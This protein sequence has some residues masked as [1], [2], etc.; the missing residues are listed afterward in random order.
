MRRS[1]AIVASWMPAIL[2]FELVNSGMEYLLFAA[3]GI[4]LLDAFE[5]SRGASLGIRFQVINFALFA[6]E[7]FL[8]MLLY[9]LIRRQFGTL[10]R[11]ALFTIGFCFVFAALFLCQMINLGIYPLQPALV[12]VFATGVALPASVFAGAGVYDSIA[13]R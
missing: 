13:H 12:F 6:G 11:A 1:A 2:A 9:A 7:M 5:I 10:P 3:T 4:S 8:V